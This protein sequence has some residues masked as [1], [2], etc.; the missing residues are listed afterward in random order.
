MPSAKVVSREID[1]STRVASFPGVYGGIVLEALKGPLEPSLLSSDKDL[2]RL[3][4]PDERIEVGMDNAF[5]SALAFLQQSQTLWVNR[6]INGGL[7]AGAGIKT[8]TATTDNF[9]AP[10]GIADPSAYV[11]DDMPDVAGVAEVSS[12]V[13]SQ[14]GT[15]YDVVGT[16]KAIQLYG[17]G[18]AGHF[19]W[20]NV[21]DGSNS[22]TAPSLVGTGHQVDILAADTSAQVAQKFAAVVDALAPFGAPVPGA[23]TVTVTNAATGSVTDASATGTAA[24][25]T[26]TTQG[27]TEVDQTDECLFI[28]NANPGAWGNDL[29]IKIITNTTAPNEVNQENGFIIQVFK[30]S[31]LSTPVEEWL[32]SR[33]ANQKDGFGQNI[34]VEDILEGSNFIRALSNPTIDESILPK[35]QSTALALG[36]GSNGTAVTDSNRVTALQAAFQNKDERLV[37]LMMDGG[38]ASSTY[39]IALDTIAANRQDSVALLSVPFSAEASASFMTDI[40]DYRRTI[41]NLNS[42]YS[43]LYTPHVKILD[44]YNDRELFVSPEGYAGAAISY[45]ASNFEIWYPPAGYKRGIVKVLDVRRRFSEGQRDTLANAQINPLRFAPGKGIAIWGQLTLQSQASLLQSLNVRLLCIVV[46][47]LI[48]EALESFLFEL[49]DSTTQALAKGLVDDAMDTYVA[50]RGVSRYLTVCDASNNLPLDVD[51]GRLILDLFITPINAVTEIRF[52]TVITS[53]GIDFSLAQQAI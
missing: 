46:R 22:Q 48:A 17:A 19:F 14:T 32:C 4:T 52:T 11:F 50:R 18:N 10:A 29:R 30:S 25:V 15:F 27:V 42:S 24:A 38:H 20:F 16:A 2:L 53:S 33:K 26:V 41:L 6:A 5:F 23:S 12:V 31:N 43:S 21:T 44:Q 40:V 47:P 45:S 39:G 37:T 9:T 1:L 35:D 13:F 3:Y 34:F 7:Y 49:N 36:G 51:A 8:I 28:Y